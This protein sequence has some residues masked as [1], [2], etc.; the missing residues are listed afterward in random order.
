MPARCPDSACG[1]GRGN[2]IRRCYPAS[3]TTANRRHIDI[4]M[5]EA[6]PRT[7][8][9]RHGYWH[10]KSRTRENLET[11]NGLAVF[12]GAS[13]DAAP[14]QRSGHANRHA[15]RGAQ[16]HRRE[17]ADWQRFRSLIAGPRT[18]TGTAHLHRR[19][20][21]LHRFVRATIAAR[22]RPSLIPNNITGSKSHYLSFTTNLNRN[23]LSAT[24]ALQFF[25]S[26]QHGRVS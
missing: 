25:S 17:M 8:C 7:I 18:R 19:F 9:A 10:V 3:L 6:I 15:A 2:S 24:F 22:G 12:A 5:A 23:V 16:D 21:N 11:A 20:E 14:A 26:G 13:P 4:S 1:E